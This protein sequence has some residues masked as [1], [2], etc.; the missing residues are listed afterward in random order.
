[1][2]RFLP[3]DEGGGASEPESH[4]SQ[5]DAHGSESDADVS[6]PDA[7][8]SKPDVDDSQDR[9]ETIDIS[10]T[11]APSIGPNTV[12]EREPPEERLARHE[13]SDV[14]AMGLDKRREVVGQS[15][16]PST[17]RQLTMYG[18]FLAVLAALVIGGKLLADKLDQPPDEVQDEAV[19]TGNDIAPAPVDFRPSGEIPTE[20]P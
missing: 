12:I 3:Q 4:A 9:G 16:G 18:I 15:Y 5:P 1:M 2:G 7:G 14:D 13:P 6:Q 8:D 20:G 11:T 19:W 10:D 17:G